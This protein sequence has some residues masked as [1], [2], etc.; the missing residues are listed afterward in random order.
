[1]NCINLIYEWLYENHKDD[2][3]ER[4]LLRYESLIKYHIVDSI[5][6]M[7]IK[8]ITPRLLQKWLNE[9]KNKNS[10]KTGKVLSP[11]SINMLI[12]LVK[13][14]FQYAVDFEILDYNPALK[15]K[16]MAKTEEETVRAFTREEQIKI[17]RYIEKLNDDE[18]FCI[19]LDLY[20]GL[21]VGELLAL[22]WKDINLKT[23][24]MSVNKTTYETR[25]DSGK[26]V[27]RV[28]VP[29]TKSSNRDIPLPTFIK[30]K[31]KEMKRIKS[32]II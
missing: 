1:M 5:G 16:R 22:T 15:L 25:L 24:I 14:V 20:T 12:A 3:K 13:L 21:R 32:R 9:I 7:N 23:G 4:T 29:K 28:S 2:I 26:W 10:E 8:D 19:I 27:K 31:L 30:D 6:E 18:Y 11:S 17:E